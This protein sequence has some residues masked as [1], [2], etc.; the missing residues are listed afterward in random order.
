MSTL[1][2]IARER[3]L[4]AERLEKMDAERATLAE[5]L[6]ELEAAE[7]VISRFTRARPQTVR[8]PGRRAATA[9]APTA[10]NPRRRRRLRRAEPKAAALSL[11]DATLRAVG[12]HSNGVSAEE[13]RRY[14]AGEFG[15]QVRA[16]HLGMALQR[17]RRGGRLEQRDSLWFADRTTGD[18][19]V[20]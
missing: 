14:L 18:A 17:H 20:P 11:S 1:D 4:L 2:D 10:A 7:R 3:Q 15:M 16:N 12:A 19:A 5:Q 9:G 6:A 13:V 8:Q